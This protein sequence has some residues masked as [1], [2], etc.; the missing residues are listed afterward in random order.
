MPTPITTFGGEQRD[1]QTKANL[2]KID[3]PYDLNSDI[4]TKSIN[5]LNNLTGYDYR[6]NSI[7]NI[8]ERLIDAQNS[9]LLQ[10][11]ATRLLVEFGRRA[12]TN[13]LDGFIPTPDDLVPNF[14]QFFKGGFRKYDTQITD[15]SKNPNRAFTDK[16]LE[17][18]VGYR[19]NENY[20]LRFQNQSNISDYAYSSNIHF[21]YSGKLVQ[22]K[23]KQLGYL[24]T[25]STYSS[26]P[27]VEIDTQSKVFQNTYNPDWLRLESS[28][29]RGLTEIIPFKD[30]EYITH[31]Y[32]TTYTK[33]EGDLIKDY[34]QERKELE[35]RQGFGSLANNPIDEKKDIGLRK[36]LDLDYK[37]NVERELIYDNLE[38]NPYVY[39]S[40]SSLQDTI[41]NDHKVKRG[42]IYFTSKLAQKNTVISQ[43]NKELYTDKDV[44]PNV[45]YYKGNGE[46]RTFTI[47][48]QHDNFSKV[49]KFDGNG[50]R[51]SV[52][53]DSVMPKIAPFKD[54]TIEDR[55]RQFFTMENLAVRV[56]ND[57]DGDQGP[58]G[59][60]WM[61]FPPYDVKLSDNNQVN[62]TDM[63]FLGRPEPIFSY[64]NTTRSL[65]LSFRLLIDTV[66]EMQDL[67]P[68]LENYRAYLYNCGEYLLNVEEFVD[69]KQTTNKKVSDK[70][71]KIKPETKVFNI[72]LKYF[73]KNDI[74]DTDTVK[75]N[76]SVL[77]DCQDWDKDHKIFISEPLLS[78]TTI[79][80][81][82]NFLTGISSATK[83]LDDNINKAKTIE[84]DI[85]G[86]ATDLIAKKNR[87][88]TEARKYNRSLGY[89]RAYGFMTE[90]ISFYNSNN[91][92]NTNIP[93]TPLADNIA[94]SENSLP[95]STY[96]FIASNKNKTK[97]IF[98]ITTK[99]DSTS[100]GPST[101]E[102]RNDPGQIQE[103]KAE[104]KTI[105]V[106]YSPEV[107]KTDN[108]VNLPETTIDNDALEKKF[109]GD[110]EERLGQNNDPA[111]TLGFDEVKK[112]NKFPTGFEKLNVFSP[113]FNSQTP[114]DFTKRYVFLHQLTRP[115]RLRNINNIE[116]TAFGRMP[117]FILRYGDFLHTKAIAR[118]IN[119]DM[120][121][122]TWDL[123]PE[124]MGAIPLYCNVTM[125]LTL[126]GG[127]SLA[128]P[129]DR[130]QTASDSSF[131][132]N[133]SFNSGRYYK[134]VRF[135]SSRKE[136]GYEYKGNGS[137]EDKTDVK[138][139]TN[140]S[141]VSPQNEPLGKI[142]RE[143]T[144]ETPIVFP[145]GTRGVLSDV[146]IEK[147]R[148]SSPAYTNT[149]DFITKK[150][151]ESQ[152]QNDIN[153]KK[154]EE[155]LLKAKQALFL[156]ENSGPRENPQFPF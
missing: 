102:N 77:D 3:S 34:I 23:L 31:S 50:E 100:V 95:Q 27:W 115:A 142:T 144:T 139:K 55:R 59:G 154:I 61:W 53:K 11:G 92:T 104:L 69:D 46:C 4:I 39:D 44:N 33:P 83:T 65:S 17:G 66:K 148:T 131:I 101:Y 143:I 136:E 56:T 133:T 80:F 135:T 45:V 132:A 67:K 12:V 47:Y 37:N 19:S 1:S 130:I 75:V 85:Q 40:L 43:N 120:S 128:G 35:G 81:N 118:S 71:K 5:L 72:N 68:T 58:N 41:N 134:N 124:G 2:Y 91:T 62:W 88:T 97:I 114:F 111:L 93:I 108:Q 99:G 112:E 10:V 7:I 15:P 117:V 116:N 151:Y 48:D 109:R 74:Y 63:N 70:I 94:P 155:N 24:N 30:T 79:A 36:N 6:N 140:A 137:G 64:N 106:T 150:Q 52:L 51:N 60:K 103:R 14:K 57:N 13:V 32:F 89:S 123:N 147:D 29:Q 156:Q 152:E 49:I 110:L 87:G 82:A 42:L 141:P 146:P 78:S 127:Q 25:F 73:F 28:S 21:Y 121:E 8:V 105:K 129:I 122:S 18:T 38:G 138:T 119:F 22:E 125:D 54:D 107:D 76:Y 126:L 96:N 98:N 20:L 113:V 90:F 9:Q 26:N 153:A 84:I 149:L 86:F 145:P 16:V